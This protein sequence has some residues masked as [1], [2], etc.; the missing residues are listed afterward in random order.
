MD[1]KSIVGAVAPTIATALG[2]PMA[3]AAVKFLGSQFLGDENASEQQVADFVQT[4]NPETLLKIKQ[5]DYEFKTQM[6]KLGVDVFKIEADDKKNAR[7]Q[8]IHSKMP[9]ILSIGLTCFIVAIVWLLFY[10]TVP[11]GAKEVLFMLLGVV[12]KEWGNSMQ[13]W[14]GTTRGSAEKTAILK[15]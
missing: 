2:G 1:W 13:Y 10:A 3:G 11:D 9:A 6:A 4:A 15:K 8:H 7:Q 5:A 14:F 12:I